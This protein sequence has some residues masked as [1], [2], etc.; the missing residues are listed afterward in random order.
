VSSTNTTTTTTNASQLDEQ[1]HV[2]VSQLQTF[3]ALL[4]KNWRLKTRGA[5]LWCFVLELLVPVAFVAL[6]CLPRLLVADTNSPSL[7]HR[8]APIES[9][10]WSRKPPRYVLGLSQILTLCLPIVRP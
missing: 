5:A 9:L 2:E 8:T 6:M 1:Q 7:F 3:K 10:S 4:K